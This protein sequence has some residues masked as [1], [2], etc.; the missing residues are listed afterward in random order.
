MD[1]I[2][3]WFVVGFVVLVLVVIVVA[4]VTSGGFSAGTANSTPPEFVATTAPTIT[5]ADWTRGKKDAKVSIIE[6]GDFECPACAEYSPV[7]NQLFAAY[8]DRVLFAFRNFPLY[9]IHPNAGISSQAA[10]AAGLQGKFWEM[11][12]LLYQKQN[13]WAG[14][15][16]S[17]VVN[18]YFDKY[19]SSLGL[20][21]NKFNQNINA[22]PVVS[23]VQADVAGG[24]AAQ[25]D[26]TPTFFVN[27]KQIPNPT[28]YNDFKAVLDGAL[29]S[30]TGS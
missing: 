30:S 28:S 9:S 7:M 21:V 3:L 13:E 18:Q 19:A 17:S 27:L 25:I 29:A 20:D 14:A 11:H 2:T 8:G 6:Y 22:N 26:H 1:K 12:D 4:G 16:S 15:A 5:A 24:N 23:K 10:E